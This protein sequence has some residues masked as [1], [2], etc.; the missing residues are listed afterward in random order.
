MNVIKRDGNIVAFNWEKIFNAV[1]KAFDE[2]EIKYSKESLDMIFGDLRDWFDTQHYKKSEM[3]VEDIQDQLVIWMHSNAYHNQAIKFM[4]YRERRSIARGVNSV[5]SVSLIDDYLNKINDMDI[6][7]NSSTMWSLQGLNNHI[8]SSLS[9]K[10]WLSLYS[11]EIKDAFDRGRIHI[12]DLST[13]GGYTYYG[14]ETVIIKRDE[15]IIFSSFEKLFDDLLPA[16]IREEYVESDDATIRYIRDVKILDKNGWTNL[17]RIIKKRKNKDMRYIRNE[18]GKDIIVTD[19]H[20]MIIKDYEEKKSQNV[21]ENEDSL[22]SV[23]VINILKTENEKLFHKDHILLSDEFKKRNITKFNDKKQ[24]YLHGRPI[25]LNAEFNDS[26]EFYINNQSSMTNRI[27]L[28]YDFGYFIGFM[29]AEGHLSINTDDM[30]SPIIS[31]SQKD[32]EKLIQL[33]DMMNKNNAFGCIKNN[34]I[35]FS[36]YFLTFII[37]S[38][39]NITPGSYNKSLPEN[40]LEYSKEFNLGIIDGLIDGDGLAGN[41]SYTL[42]LNNKTIL[43]QVSTLLRGFGFFPKG[44]TPFGANTTHHFQDKEIHQNYDI[45]GIIFRNVND[46]LKCDKSSRV[47]RSTSKKG[48][49]D[50]FKEGWSKVNKNTIVQIKDE[51]IYD[52]TTQTNTLIVNDMWNHNCAGWDLKEVITKGFGGVPGKPS[53]AP[54]KHFSSALSQA[55]N[56]IFTLQGETAGAQAFSN[57]NT[58]MAPF[59]FYDNLSYKQVKQAIQEFIFNLNISTRVG[60]Q[61]PFSNLTL[62]LDPSKTN[63][64]D[65]YVIVGG[66]MQEKQYKDF[67]RQSEWINTAIIETMEA[68][69]ANGAML[70]YPIITFNVTKDFPWDNKF[71]DLLLKTTAKYGSFYFANY[72]NSDYSSSDVTSMCCRLRIDRTEVEKHA[73]SLQGLESEE[74]ETSHQKG[75]GFFGAAP[76]T[77]SIGVVTLGLPAIMHDAYQHEIHTAKIYKLDTDTTEQ[78]MEDVWVTFLD[79]VKYYMDLAIESLEKKR[80][81]IEQKADLGLY[82]YLKVYLADIKKKTGQYFAQHFSTICPNGFHE[83]LIEWGLKDGMM[84]KKGQDYAEKL[85]KFMTEYSIILQKENRCLLN[86]EQ[87]PAESAGV[88]L[89]TKSGIDP[90]NNGYYTNSTWLPADKPKDTFEQINIQGKLN[91]YYSGGSSL[92]TYTDADLVPIYKDL[93]KIILYAFE[94]TKLPYMTISPVF[95]VCE[96]CGRIPGR[97]SVCPKCSSEKMQTFSRVVGYYRA[98]S[99]FNEGRRKEAEERYFPKI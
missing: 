54:P 21:V 45:M 52:I 50:H 30:F 5:D 93:K 39:F 62:D 65:D 37:G 64:A 67:K 58:L 43:N 70:S 13:I 26:D 3:K 27:D 49:I 56:F 89:C 24:I 14:K 10:Y 41:N 86:I 42:R 7:E 57:F 25:D 87:A 83:A 82:P 1:R 17:Q 66:E 99:N 96:N 38:I 81:V 34:S 78:L 94:N 63:Y 85:L 53:S 44:Q 71:G 36:N 69:D 74:Y 2:S 46:T 35:V 80:K 84:S 75:G 79:K 55:N 9:E 40:I 33:H 59:V 32:P 61:A 92:H 88:K 60:F 48:C 20:P 11:D 91:E 4:K 90:L 77:G 31:I 28:T 51:Y 68:G 97:H 76:K 72:I 73:K 98:E 8:F 47:T 15:Q 12:H 95:S 18:N 29:L 16:M 22:L 6:N 19:D 23:D